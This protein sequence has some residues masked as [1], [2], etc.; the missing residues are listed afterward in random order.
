MRNRIKQSIYLI[1]IIVMIYGG[2]RLYYRVTGGFTIGNITSDLTYDP[3]WETRPLTADRQ[4]ELDSILSQEFTY[5]GK[6]CQS[7]VFQSRDGTAVIKF[8]KYQR[9][10]PQAW[11]EYFTFIPAVER[12]LNHKVEQ[13]RIKRENIFTSWK[14]AFDELQSETGLLYVHLNKTHH[15]HKTLLIYDK[16]GMQH[17]IDLDQ[18]EFLV[19]RKAQPLC[20]YIDDLMNNSDFAGAQRL[21][22]QIIT[23]VLAEY[24]RGLADNDHAL[25]QNTGVLNGRPIHIDVGQFVR[26][27]AVRTPEVYKQELFSKTFKFR[28]WLRQEYPPLAD[29]LEE[30][31]RALIGEQFSSMKPRLKTHD[32]GA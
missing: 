30:K 16:M 10:R 19:Q 12:Y 9:F 28:R 5:L 29:D 32:E 1:V 20:P 15:L 24:K 31:L 8:F 18:M 22:S 4:H 21:M 25:M 23:L 14:L 2:G 3:R 17:P 26:N 6:G 11:L 27:D 13:K 7:Y